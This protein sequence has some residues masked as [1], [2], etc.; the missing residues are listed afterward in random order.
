MENNFNNKIKQSFENYELPYDSSAWEQMSKKLDVHMPVKSKPN[1]KI[2]A[3][4]TIVTLATIS[5]FI[6]ST[7]TYVEKPVTSSTE[8]EKLS[9]SETKTTI[10]SHA[11]IEKKTTEKVAN[12]IDEI[13]KNSTVIEENKYVSPAPQKTNKTEAVNTPLTNKTSIN[14]E[15]KP[16]NTI[17]TIPEMKN[18]CFGEEVEIANVNKTDIVLSF[19]NG[20]TTSI[21][22]GTKTSFKSVISGEYDLGYMKNET[23]ITKENFTVYPA[24]KVDF[25]IDN[26]NLYSEGIPTINLKANTNAVNYDWNF[27]NVKMNS[28][29]KETEVHYYKA[30]TYKIT[31]TT[32][33]ENGC[34]A[35]ETNKI[36]VKE[37]YNLM[38]SNTLDLSSDNSK[39]NTFMPYALTV[40]NV[41]FVMTILDATS[42]EIVFQTDDAGQPWDGTDKRTGNPVTGTNYI[43]KV[44]LSNPQPGESANY[45]GVITRL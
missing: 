41:K 9:T 30:G 40:R 35:S 31:L 34:T 27:E 45:K 37:D 29:T 28:Q 6:Y 21:K 18:I 15:Y 8:K 24:S 38:A 14:S 22:A 25:S 43:W 23:F 36:T 3:A 7:S 4:A 42:G 12:S 1:Y 26:E 19:P 39:I 17:P 20:K 16:C 13:E 11:K 44:T 5:A 2:W 33:Y 10:S 32:T